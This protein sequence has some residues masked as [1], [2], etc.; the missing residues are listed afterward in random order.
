MQTNEPNDSF[1]LWTDGRSE[2]FDF[3]NSR[4][5]AVDNQDLI[6]MHWEVSHHELDQQDDLY[7]MGSFVDPGFIQTPTPTVST[8][9]QRSLT[10][11]QFY[12]HLAL[13]AALLEN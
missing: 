1:S 11:F 6:L 5:Q 7:A 12:S 3:I 9:M 4:V 10:C 8:T 2:E 13:S